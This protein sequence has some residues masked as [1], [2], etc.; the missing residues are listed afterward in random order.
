MSVDD[1]FSP[2]YA[3]ARA[4]FL[5]AAAGAGLA[6]VSHPHPLK[7][8]GGED[9]SLD[10]VTLCPDA[11]APCRAE[12]VFVALSATHGVEGFVGSAAQ[13]A[14][15]KRGHWK[16]TPPG[17][18]VLLL[19]AVNPH[20]FAWLRRVTE[21][22]VDL[23]R[24]FADF[25][26]ALPRKPAYD[27]LANAICPK[28]WDDRTIAAADAQLTDFAARHGQRTLS[29]A[30]MGGQYSHADGV[31]YGGVK[32]TWSRE[33]IMK[34]LTSYCSVAKHVA[35]L[36]F[37]TGLGESGAGVSYCVGDEGAPAVTKAHEVW[38][39]DANV[40]AAAP[41]S[42]VHDGYNLTGIARMISPAAVYGNTLEFGTYPTERMIRALR[43]DNWLHLH[44][45]PRSE[46]GRAIKAEIKA[47][48]YPETSAEWK[49][50]VM[51]RALAVWDRGMAG[52]ADA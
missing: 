33:T 20:G 28:S 35:I 2:D 3:T 7:G 46:Q 15:L 11:S 47:V 22:N 32:P 48:F 5:A 6:V 51:T 4:K 41:G 8:P 38:G 9:L 18:S 49:T 39:D 25:S 19:H 21:D 24:N 12:R 31:F 29:R 42:G 50:R 52:L 40:M 34:I 30:I 43:A 45:D 13:T 27:E 26:K 14:W 37:H 10:L 36:D 23:N 44:G 1:Y 16:R 17:M